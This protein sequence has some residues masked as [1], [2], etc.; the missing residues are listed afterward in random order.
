ML[1]WDSMKE[2]KFVSLSDL[3]KRLSTV[4]DK[5]GVRLYRDNGLA[6]AINNKD[7]PK[8]DRITK[9][10]IALFKEEE[11]SITLKTNLIETEF[12]LQSW[13]GE[14]LSFLKVYQNTTLHQRL[15]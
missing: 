10:I 1:Q 15:F 8:L 6:A 5:S 7:G 13:D 4:I 2:P 14:I 9:D 11:I 12:Y 3:L